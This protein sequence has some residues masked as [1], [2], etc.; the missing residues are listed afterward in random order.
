MLIFS[1]YLP[2]W[3]LVSCSLFVKITNLTLHKLHLSLTHIKQYKKN[4]EMYVKIHW[5]HGKISKKTCFFHNFFHFFG[6]KGQIP[7]QMKR[8]KTISFHCHTFIHAFYGNYNEKDISLK[9]IIVLKQ[10]WLV[11][12]VVYL[13]VWVCKEVLTEF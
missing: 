3:I 9:C 7:K 13:L 10:L 8:S 6:I 5:I 2:L 1:V 12:L 11:C 4:Y